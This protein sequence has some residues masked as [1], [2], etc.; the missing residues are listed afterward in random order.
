MKTFGEYPGW[1]WAL[2]YGF[3]VSRLWSVVSSVLIFA[4]A[5]LPA[6]NVVVVRFLSETLIDAKSALLVLVL[7]GFLFGAGGALQQIANASS[8]VNALRVNTHAGDQFDRKMTHV[9][10]VLYES[11]EFMSTVRKARQ[12][13]SEGHPSSQFQASINIV[14]AV[15][16]AG[17]LAVALYDL[18]AKAAFISIFAPIPTALAYAWYGRQEAKYWPIAAEFNRRSVYLQDQFSYYR[19][20]SELATMNATSQLALGAAQS[21]RDYRKIR[22]KLEGKSVISDSLSGMVTT[23]LFI[24]ALVFL[25][26]DAQHDVGAVFAG[27]IGLMSGIS[28]MAGIGYQVGELAISMPAN[29]HLRE[30][31]QIDTS[32]P[33]ESIISDVTSVSV[34]NVGVRYDDLQAVRDV[35][36]NVEQGSLCALVG[37]NGSGKTTMIKALQGV[38]NDASGSILVDGKALN[39]ADSR[40]WF[41]FA[42]VH[43]DYGRYELSV[44]DFV[45]LGVPESVI[46]ESNIAEALRFAE[47]E[48]FVSALPQ[49][50]DSMLGVQWGGSELS[51]GQWQ[52]L[53]IARAVLT[54]AP[55]WFMDEP[56]SAV[57]APTEQRIFDRLAREAERRIIILSSHRVSTLRGVKN[58]IVLKNGTVCETGS[59]Q[60]LMENETEFYR[61]FSTQLETA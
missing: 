26:R 59:Y 16:T 34:Q 29:H 6:I 46:S 37:E 32:K 11:E 15:I 36:F 21:R 40:Q 50:L 39:L 22:E 30:L 45:T 10:A 19:T 1:L 48:E 12:C 58:I 41:A 56:T 24:V 54:D 57:D 25:Y 14:S 23:V 44:R 55:V 43:Q 42:S 28:A 17:T 18:S 38:Q 61:M 60:E 3:S 7:T 13:I 31:L 8:R 5:F 20:G 4:V 47:A 52:R 27:I 53:A 2:R 33:Q 35:A 49:G 9:P 51:G